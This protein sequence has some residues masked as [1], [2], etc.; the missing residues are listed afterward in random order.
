MSHEK[1]HGISIIIPYR[2]SKKYSRQGKNFRW[3]KEYWECNLPG[4]EVI[5]GKDH[6]KDKSFSKSVAVNHGV[7]KSTGD[8]LVIV[9]ADGYLEIESVLKAAREIRKARKLGRKLWFIPYRKFYRLT[10]EAAQKVLD[11][12]PCDPYQFP[13]PPYTRDIQCQ[14]GSGKGRGHWFGALVQIVPREAF[15]CVGGWDVRFRGWGGE[16]HSIMRATD[17]LFGRHKTLP[18]AVFHLWHPMFSTEGTGDWFGWNKRLWDNQE[19]AGNNFGLAARYSK[20]FGSKSKMQ[21]LVNEGIIAAEQESAPVIRAILK[22]V[23]RIR[24]G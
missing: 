11:S 14:L 20:A 1:G 6:C 13:T 12:E 23:K 8:I 24:R 15:D 22:I 5:Q 3:L 4:A 19:K 7:R 9:D 16:D 2:A 21:K 10:D 17:T 18:G